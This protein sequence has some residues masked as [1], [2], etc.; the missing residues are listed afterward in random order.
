MWNA[1]KSNRARL[2]PNACHLIT[3]ML[4]SSNL[5]GSS[6]LTVN[7]FLSN[8]KPH[9]EEEDSILIWLKIARI[10]TGLLIFLQGRKLSLLC[11]NNL[12]VTL[13]SAHPPN[14]EYFSVRMNTNCYQCRLAEVVPSCW[15]RKVLQTLG[16]EKDTS[17]RKY[18]FFIWK[19]CASISTCFLSIDFAGGLNS[20]IL[21]ARW[22]S[23]VTQRL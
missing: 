1:L 20:S 17:T 19:E 3:A 11:F 5:I 14:L 18:W 6:P 7:I 15:E 10:I 12:A 2:P 8:A 22:E 4:I 21:T 13:R 9:T 23:A 16:N